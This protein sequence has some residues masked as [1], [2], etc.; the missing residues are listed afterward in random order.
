[1]CFLRFLWTSCIKYI[2]AYGLRSGRIV[3]GEQTF[4]YLGSAD[5]LYIACMIMSF[6]N[7]FMLRQSAFLWHVVL[8]MI[9]DEDGAE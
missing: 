3:H 2:H 4:A 7:L 9:T 8:D 5:L 1:M 6:R